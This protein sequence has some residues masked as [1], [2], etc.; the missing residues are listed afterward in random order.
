[1]QPASLPPNSHRPYSGH[2]AASVASHL[3][4]LTRVFIQMM[5]TRAHKHIAVM[6]IRF[7]RDCFGE[8]H[9]NQMYSGRLAPPSLSHISVAQLPEVSSIG[10]V[11]VLR[12]EMR[13]LILACSQG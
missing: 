2:S 8:V 3:P 1:M 13:S 12:Q 6:I 9:I 11:S 10:P 4:Q 5:N 7:V